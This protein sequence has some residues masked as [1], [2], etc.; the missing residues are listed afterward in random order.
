M[1]YNHWQNIILLDGYRL[2][3]IVSEDDQVRIG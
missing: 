3:D 1:N 2:M